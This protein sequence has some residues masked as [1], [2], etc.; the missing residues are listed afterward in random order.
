MLIGINDKQTGR[1]YHICG[2]FPSASG[3]TNLAMMLAPDA[4]GDRYHVAF[5]GDDIAW[6]WVDEADGKLYGM[7]PEYG[8]FGVAKDTNEST[9][10]TALHRVDRARHRAHLHQRRLQRDDP[11]GLVGGPHARAAGRHRTAGSTGR[12]SRSPTASP[13][14]TATWAHPN[15]RFTTTLDNVPNVAA[16]YDAAAGRADR[17]DHLRRPHPRPRAADPRD[18]RPRR[19]RLRRP[20]ARR[21]GDR[22]PPRASRACCATTRCRCARSW[23]TARATTPRTGSRSSARPRTSRSSRTSTGSSATREDGHFLWPGYRDNLR[24]LLW[25]LQLKNGEVTGRADR[26]SASSRPQEE[27][28]LDGVDI[29]PEDLETHPVDQRAALAAGDGLPRG[30]PQAVRPTCPRR[31]GR[32]TAASPPPSTPRADERY[33]AMSLLR[34]LGL[35][36]TTGRVAEPAPPAPEPAPGVSPELAG[37]VQVRHVDAGSC[38]GCE[39]EVGAAFGPVY[40]ADRYGARLVASPRHADVVLVTGV[41]TRNMLAPL[42]RTVEATPQPRVV[43]AVGDCAR[44]LWRVPERLRRGRRGQTMWWTSTSRSLAARRSRSR[45]SRRCGG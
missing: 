2:G 32:R 4:L 33:L 19:G 26:R 39:I 25:L 3:K 27:L 16:D 10:P 34:L 37:S 9:N 20:D 12:A 40:D 1:T 14:T 8:V 45:S 43:L 42:L 41:V 36:R 23:P 35:I 29:T 38:N 11:R 7:N 15:S 22:S 6:L 13:A 30:A 21:R 5:Y 44:Q 28:N 18:H 17:R 31:S 24:P